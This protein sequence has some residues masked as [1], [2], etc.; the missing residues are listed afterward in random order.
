MES[1]KAK[2]LMY[3]CTTSFACGL[4]FG[5]LTHDN[6]KDA[7]KMGLGAAASSVAATWVAKRE[8][9]QE[10]FETT[11]VVAS[12][13]VKAKVEEVKEKIKNRS[14][15]SE[16]STKAIASQPPRKVITPQ[17]PRK[18]LPEQQQVAEQL[19][20]STVSEGELPPET[21]EENW[22]RE[23]PNP[24]A[25]ELPRETIQSDLPQV[26]P[27][28]ESEPEYDSLVG[29]LHQLQEKNSGLK[30]QL[31]E[32]QQQNQ[33]LQTQL[34]LSDEQRQEW[35][36]ALESLDEQS[37]LFQAKP[38]EEQVGLEDLLDE[39]PSGAKKQ[40][41]P[42]NKANSL[43]EENQFD[44]ALTEFSQRLQTPDNIQSPPPP[45]PQT[46]S[47]LP[48]GPLKPRQP[49][50]SS[51]LPE[52]PLKPRQPRTSS[53]LPEGPLKPRQLKEI[54][55]L[56]GELA[57]ELED[58]VAEDS[59]IQSISPP[60]EL[61]FDDLP[62]DLAEEL[63]DMVDFLEDDTSTEEKKSILSDEQTELEQLF[64]QTP[65]RKKE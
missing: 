48:E 43:D 50:T 33:S 6:W 56:P 26:P 17:P 58:I 38:S 64:G 19:P 57:D 20:S 16:S 41:S 18:A 55:E 34:E 46:S 23:I 28:P 42:E 24:V 11:L 60:K 30:G 47:E 31:Q 15:P 14:N 65:D 40:S 1:I 13:Q 9:L 36:Q 61:D 45:T 63:E 62:S 52:G 32:L 59:S 35:N 49:R 51:E 7:G 3:L 8:D 2:Q 29:Q 12:S 25:E 37:E 21:V 10:K 44:K 39:I 53:E 22:I 54:D 5:L 27:Q 4:V